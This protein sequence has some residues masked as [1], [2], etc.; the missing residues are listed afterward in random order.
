M[1]EDEIS[2]KIE[3]IKA[4]SESN[5]RKTGFIN[6]MS[7]SLGAIITLTLG[8]KLSSE[9]GQAQSNIALTLSALLTVINGWGALFNYRK[10]WLRQKNTLLKLYQI[11]NELKYRKSKNEDFDIDELFNKYQKV[12]EQDGLEWQI[13]NNSAQTENKHKN[14]KE[15]I[16]QIA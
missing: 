11:Q 1:L 5:K 9:Y 8:L 3:I 14:N 7:L 16:T 10:L 13:I 4:K 15:K 6:G 2:S 12:W